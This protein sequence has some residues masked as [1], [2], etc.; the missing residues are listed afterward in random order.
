MARVVMWIFLIL[1]VVLLG[2]T[3]FNLDKVN[4]LGVLI[5]LAIGGGCAYG[6]FFKKKAS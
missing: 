5:W 1:A 2:L 4:P 3:L 6:L